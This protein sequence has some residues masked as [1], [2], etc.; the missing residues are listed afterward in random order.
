[1]KETLLNR[2]G[3]TPRAIA[4]R[5]VA[6]IGGR[7]IA[8]HGLRAAGKTLAR[9]GASPWLVGADVAQICAGKIASACDCD[10]DTTEAVSKGAGALTSVAI[11]A[12][13]AGPLGAVAG[14]AL[15]AV[16]EGIGRLF[17]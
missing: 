13:V 11:G 10:E 4:R 16:G 17:E 14:G 15:W 5:E 2:W 3:M 1:M 8:K 6:R 9:T 12:A 7:A